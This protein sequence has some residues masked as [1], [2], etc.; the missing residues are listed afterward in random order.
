[1]T[2]SVKV[3]RVFLTVLD[4]VGI[5]AAPDA[6]DYGDSG[7]S[8]LA[9]LAQAAG[10]LNVPTLT[11]MGLG[12]IPGLLP[13]KQAIKGV[14]EQPCPSAS[15]GAMQELSRGKDTTTGHWEIAGLHLT[16]GFALFPAGPPAFPSALTEA[17]EQQTGRGLLGNRAA[18]GTA[19]IEELGPAHQ[20]S[21]KWIVYTS[22]DSVLQIAAHEDTIPLDELYQACRH[23]R[24]LCNP[25]RVGRVI[26]RPFTGTSGQYARTENRRDF[27]YPLPEPCILDVLGEAGV[28]TVTVG[29][30]D[31]IFPGTHIDQAEHVENNTDAE[32][33]LLDLITSADGPLFVFTNLIDFD[34]LHGHRRDPLGYAAA[35]ESTDKALQA[36]LEQ[37][38]PDDVFILTADHGNDPTFPGSDHTREWVPLLVTRPGFPGRSLGLRQGFFDIAQSVASLFGLPP[39]PRGKAFRVET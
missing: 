15:F 37:L 2:G 5:G 22:A 39:M 21:G 16:E 19:I 7:A 14:P 17:F 8:T 31:D 25:Y 29:K 9:H 24:E 30:L 18:S 12:N 1:M 27:S 36:M 3:L 26:A 33:C 11:R 10:G 13:G 4:S 32:A 6:A 35:L 20:A 23:A 34:M 28:R 38:R